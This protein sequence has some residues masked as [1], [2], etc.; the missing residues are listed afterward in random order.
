MKRH[1]LPGLAVAIATGAMSTLLAAP[2]GA[3]TTTPKYRGAR[4]NAVE[5]E[6]EAARHG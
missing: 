5:R 6:G 2:S 4:V 1:I 3:A